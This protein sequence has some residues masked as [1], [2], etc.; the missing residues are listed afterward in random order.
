M[1]VLRFT[2]ILAGAAIMLYGIDG[3]LTSPQI[4]HPENVARWMLGG[5]VLHDAVLAPVVFVLAWLA[6]RWTPPRVRWILGALLLTG[7]ALLLVA[8]PILLHGRVA[9]R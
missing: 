9:I 6:T 2:A 4:L 3:L 5:V 7:G 8:A 1:R